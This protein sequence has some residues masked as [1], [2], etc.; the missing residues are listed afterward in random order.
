[1]KIPIQLPKIMAESGNGRPRT[2]SAIRKTICPPSSGGTGKKFNTA[3]LML[4]IP[5]KWTSSVSSGVRLR[6]G[7]AGN[8]DRSPQELGAYLFLGRGCGSMA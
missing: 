2:F 3:R 6:V 8:H 4:K 1:M 5:R 7:D